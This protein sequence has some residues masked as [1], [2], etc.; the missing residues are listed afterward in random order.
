MVGVPDEEWG[1][2]IEAVV[3]P[4]PG[5][6]VDP[7]ALRALV[8][9][10]LRGSK[11]P[12]RIHVL[13]GL[14]RTETGKLIR[15]EAAACSR[16]YPTASRLAPALAP[17]AP[18]SLG[19]D[20][21]PVGGLGGRGRGGGALQDVHRARVPEADHVGQPHPGTLDLAVARLT[22]QVGRDLVDVGD[23]GG[24][25]GVPLGL[26]PPGDVDWRRAVAQVVPELKKSAAPPSS[27]SRRL[28]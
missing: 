25:D 22:A 20:V 14:P 27:H 9:S 28:S 21:A 2:R 16:P 5:G 13:G 6:S 17:G 11:T 7:E 3:V 26:K 12:D 18:A 10:K 24:G 4:V 15:R 19:R 8:R 23:P 1:E